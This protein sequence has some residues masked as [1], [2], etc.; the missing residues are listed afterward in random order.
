MAAG[1][2]ERSADGRLVFV[3]RSGDNRAEG[4]QLS[5]FSHHFRF[6]TCGLSD[7]IE[8]GISKGCLKAQTTDEASHDKRCGRPSFHKKIRREAL[9]FKEC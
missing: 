3:L 9:V 5:I 2:V 4:E 6:W 8:T 1:S 7:D